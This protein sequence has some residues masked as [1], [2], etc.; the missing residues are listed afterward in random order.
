MNW[1]AL[2]YDWGG[3]NYALFHAINQGTPAGFALAATLLGMAGSYWTAPPLGLGLWWWAKADSRLDRALLIRRQLA[4]FGVAFAFALLSAA[5]L[6]LLFDF[7]RPQAV[8]GAA[9]HVIGDAELHYS[10]PSG[11]STYAALVAGTLWPLADPRS[12]ISLGAYVVLVGWSRVAAG[13]HFPADV[14]AG[15]ALALGCLSAS[16]SVIRT[17]SKRS[18]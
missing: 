6:K 11:H 3:L 18:R 17:I 15:W 8:F 4:R 2:L 10:L 9:V 16:C 1:K 14:L 5:F 12:R 13:M 7:P